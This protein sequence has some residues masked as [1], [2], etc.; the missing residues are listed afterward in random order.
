M[1]NKRPKCV[2]VDPDL[3]GVPYA[4]IKPAMAQAARDAYLV[5][6]IAP[7]LL[8]VIEPRKDQQ[9]YSEVKRVG[10]EGLNKPV[11]TQVLLGTNFRKTGGQLDQVS[12]LPMMRSS[13]RP[14]STSTTSP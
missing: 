3:N 14:R 4:G 12:C 9:L 10:A 6:K 11:V 7:Q 5:D 1:V 2:R 13:L 8:V